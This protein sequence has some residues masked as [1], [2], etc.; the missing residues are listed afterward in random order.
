MTLRSLLLAWLS[1]LALAGTAVGAA[2]VLV[3]LNKSDDTVSLL[4][5]KSGESLATIAVGHAPHE[6]A[7]TRDGR[8]A[9]VANYGDRA[10]PG[11]TISVLDLVKRK[12]V[13]TIDLGEHRRPHGICLT[14]DGRTLYVT[15]EG[16]KAVLEI[17]T[18][19]ERIRR[20]F[21]TEQLVSHM[22]VLTPDEKKLYV[23]NLGS[24]SVSV[25]NLATGGVSRVETGDGPEGV[26]ISPDGREV[27]VANRSDGDIVV[28]DAAADTAIARFPA[29]KF[30]IR[31]K[32]TPDGRHVLVS[33][34]EGNEVAVFEAAKRAAVARIPTGEAPIGILVEPDGKYAWVAQTA[35]DRVSRID[36]SAWKIAGQWTAGR[37]PDGLGWMAAPAG[38][39]SPSPSR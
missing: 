10:A 30:P 18:A 27:W 24:R 17:D 25:V 13:S 4:N 21:P 31:V 35:A 19:S 23:A 28:L 34:G 37:E 7:V 11:R 16:T 14:R 9:Y 3:V 38:Q 39:A 36:L 22:C 12:V 33:N 32:F 1:V 29:G 2:P 5:P 26:D 15:V 8:V 20:A 6:V